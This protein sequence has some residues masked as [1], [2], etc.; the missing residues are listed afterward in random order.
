ML[1]RNLRAGVRVCMYDVDEEE[2]YHATCMQ[3]C[4]CIGACVRVSISVYIDEND[5]R[6]HVTYM[7]VCV[8][9][10]ARG[11]AYYVDKYYVDGI[12]LTGLLVQGCAEKA[13]LKC[14][15]VIGLEGMHFDEEGRCSPA[16]HAHTHAHIFR[17][18]VQA[19]VA[20]AAAVEV[21]VGV[22]EEDMALIVNMC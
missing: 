13:G 19:V 10:F 4:L 6:C 15:E 17:A 8:C 3:V 2:C 14:K 20:A 5:E 22:S 21:R 12:M 7:P 1:P 11:F 16:T 18:Y 9:G